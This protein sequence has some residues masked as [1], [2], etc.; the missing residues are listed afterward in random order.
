MSEDAA[1]PTPVP[2]PD[3]K[4]VPDPNG[5]PVRVASRPLVHAAGLTAMVVT[6]GGAAL[7]AMGALLTPCVGALRSVRLLREQRQQE[8][9]AAKAHMELTQAGE[10]STP[11]DAA[12]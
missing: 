12:Q 5:R 10:T 8:I 7:M 3:S 4:G 2:P 9:L 11:L 6:A 1:Q